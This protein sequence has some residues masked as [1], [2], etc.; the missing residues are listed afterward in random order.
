MTEEKWLECT[1]PTPTLEF[2]RGKA[3]GRKLRLFACACCRRHWRILTDER[4]RWAVGVGERVADALAT[5]PERETANASVDQATHNAIVKRQA[6]YTIPEHFIIAARA[7]G[8]TVMPDGSLDLE[9]ALAVVAACRLML[10]HETGTRDN[11]ASENAALCSTLREVFSN[12]FRP[13]TIAPA[14]LTPAVLSLAQAAYEERN[15][16]AGT[17]DNARIAVL[18]DALEDAG[19]DNADILDHCRQPGEHVRG[20]WVLDFLLGKQ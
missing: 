15:L 11:R 9:A 20:C 16:P 5:G 2:L 18:A 3:S 1:E 4:S 14:W 17:L 8:Y 12:P 13:I 19:C 7:A 10:L 6:N